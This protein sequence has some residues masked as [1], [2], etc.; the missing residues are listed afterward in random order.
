MKQEKGKEE[1]FLIDGMSI[2]FRSYYAL[3]QPNLKNNNNEPT[4]AI[5]GFINTITNIIK[6]YAPKY[7]LV[8]FDSHAPTFR[9]I[10][11]NEYKANRPKCPDDLLLQLPYIKTFLNIAGIKQ[12]EMPGFEADDIIGTLATK[13]SSSD[14]H[15]FCITGDKDFFQLINDNITI[16]KNKHIGSGYNTINKS[17]VYEH[18]KIMPNQVID[19]LALCGDTSDN[20]PGVKGIG[21]KTAA[22]LLYNFNS[23]DNI[24]N[25]IDTA[26]NPTDKIRNSILSKL[27]ENKDKAFLSKKLVT[28]DTNIN[29]KIKNKEELILNTPN[30]I[31]LNSFFINLNIKMQSKW[32]PADIINTIDTIQPTKQENIIKKEN[33]Y[34]L[35]TN[36]KR[37]NIIAKLSQAPLLSIHINTDSENRFFSN[38]IGISISNG[39]ETYYFDI[40]NNNLSANFNNEFSL[41]SEID[42]NDNTTPKLIQNNIPEALEDL[43]EIFENPNIKKCGYDLKNCIFLLKRFKIELKNIDLDIALANYIIDSETDNSI[44]SICKK[45][46]NYTPLNYIDKQSTKNKESKEKIDENLILYST[47]LALIY[48]D[49]YDKLIDELNKNE[50]IYIYNKIERPL[51]EILSDMEINGITINS[52][53][54]K[55]LSEIITTKITELQNYIYNYIGETFNIDSSKQLST[56]LFEKLELPKLKKI[57]TGYSTSA[58]TL[59]ELAIFDPII[60]YILEYKK[61]VKLNTTYIE[62][63]PKLAIENKIH[64]TF[65]QTIAST[66]RLTSI[67][68]NLQNIPIKTK[69]GREIRKGFI[70]KNKD[71]YLLSADYSQIELRVMAYLSNDNN[72]IE[73]FK[74]SEDVHKITATKIFNLPIENITTEKRN[75]AKTVNFGI[76]YGIEAY[77]LSKR[78]GISINNATELIKNYFYRFPNIKN[79]IEKTIEEVRKNGYAK[80]LTGRKRYFTDINSKKHNIRT[81]AERAAVNM[82]VQGTASDMIKIAMINIYNEFNRNNLTS[83]MILQIHD[84]LLFDVIH[85]ELDIVKNIVYKQMTTGFSLGEVPIEVHISYGKNWFEAHD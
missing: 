31:E 50:L 41:F 56:I 6:K 72:L 14:V 24:Y 33:N 63:I 44:V 77:G 79:F 42:N 11:Y 15:T 13:L 60:E 40:P 18:L 47:E 74:T 53:I 51:I 61:L 55:Q 57:K 49:L 8:A 1:I 46:L 10:L 70:P 23:L 17:E 54:F 85:D 7:M 3:K 35:V 20:I 30:Y 52:Q 22:D 76:M 29:I 5:Y 43:K 19:F 36:D 9:H 71:S 45:F 48:F 64:T 37:K 81:A 32:I 73:A 26:P 68:P 67:E 16:L 12:I 28:I 78:L 66:G 75:I 25:Y 80:T 82:P 27:K 59:Q 62:T 2:V 84:E 34:H 4:G 38:I 58:E 39:K 83:K 65:K 69:I 21:E